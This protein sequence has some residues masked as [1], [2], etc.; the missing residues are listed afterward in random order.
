MLDVDTRKTQAPI[1]ASLIEAF[2]AEAVECSRSDLQVTLD[3]Q[4]TELR[5]VDGTPGGNGL[6]EALLRE[7]R[8]ATAL[9]TAARVVRAQ[10]RKGDEAF[11]RYLVEECRTD[12]KLNAKEIADALDRMADAWKG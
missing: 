5:V 12:S 3:A 10:G 11:R 7:G 6:S 4:A 8:V 1:L 2:F 9:A